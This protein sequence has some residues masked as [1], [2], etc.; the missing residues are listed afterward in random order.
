[1]STL[2]ESIMVGVPVQFA[3]REWS[4]FMFRRLVGHYMTSLGEITWGTTG[5]ESDADAGIVRFVTE[6]DQLAKV[7][8]ELEYEP[9]SWADSEAEE[10]TVRK[11]LR[12]DLVLYREFLAKRCEEERCLDSGKAR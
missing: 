9:H 3:D 8:V 4:E 12:D 11:R 6:G 1:M 10:E 2:S 5:D 7:T